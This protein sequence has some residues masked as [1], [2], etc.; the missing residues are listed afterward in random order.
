MTLTQN[1]TYDNYRNHI[2]KNNLHQLWYS[3]CN[4]KSINGIRVNAFTPIYSP[5][6][7]IKEESICN[8]KSCKDGIYKIPEDNIENKILY[9]KVCNVCG[10]RKTI[11]YRWISRFDKTKIWFKSPEEVTRY[12]NFGRAFYATLTLYD[13]KIVNPSSKYIDESFIKAHTLGIDID[14]EKGTICDL[15]N[16]ENLDKV[17]NIIKE[18]LDIANINKSYNL[19]SSGNGVY[20]FL[21]HLLC[22]KDIRYTCSMYNSW[23]KHLS[24]LCEKEGIKGIS[25]DP[26]NMMSRVYKLVGSIHQ[27]YDLVAIPLEHDCKLS[28][29]KPEE[30]K[31]K[32]FNLNKF[33]KEIDNVLSLNFYNRI[34]EREK[35]N[36]YR[37]L[38]EHSME[39]ESSHLRA[40]RHEFDNRLLET[41]KIGIESI[42]NEEQSI[43]TN[44]LRNPIQPSTQ[45]TQPSNE[46]FYNR[47]VGWK[48]YDLDIPGRVNYKIT[49]QEDLRVEFIGVKKDDREKIWNE[50]QEKIKIP[51]ELK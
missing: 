3:W 35:I 18:Q 17:L 16:R 40:Y 21:H 42:T 6:I 7:V 13:K 28:E 23:I 37:F 4:P 44:I 48:K 12:A 38:E 49:P 2:T 10:A 25:I 34:D 8:K 51:K 45:H 14:I 33:Y 43:N 1:W 15:K 26:I 24:L 22:T 39:L 31:L 20:V 50:I 46:E 5:E 11:L 19:Q 29:M 36:L 9:K 30:F 32:Y 41:Q 47:Y 27:K